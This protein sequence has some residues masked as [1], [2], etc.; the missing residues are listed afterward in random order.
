MSLKPRKQHKHYPY[1]FLFNAKSF[2][3]YLRGQYVEYL[4]PC[5]CSGYYFSRTKLTVY[6]DTYLF[7]KLKVLINKLWEKNKLIYAPVLC[8]SWVV[9][10]DSLVIKRMK[11]YIRDSENLYQK[12]KTREKR[13]ARQQLRLNT[14]SSGWVAF[15]NKPTIENPM[16][17]PREKKW[18]QKGYDDA[19]K[20]YEQERNSDSDQYLNLLKFTEKDYDK[21]EI[22][23][24]PYIFKNGIYEL[25]D[26]AENILLT[27]EDFQSFFSFLENNHDALS[28]IIE[29]G[30]LQSNCVRTD[31]TP[32]LSSLI[33]FQEFIETIKPLLNSSIE[34]E[35]NNW[36]Q[37]GCQYINIDFLQKHI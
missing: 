7:N 14:W 12:R 13:E 26:G 16:L 37:L 30:E 11:S 25:I 9:N 20:D 29:S 21:A 31:G 27:K 33:M 4:M 36:K 18:W 34:D 19:K 10:N 8:D 2:L 24:I 3:K 32:Y 23:I 5:P 22:E 15:K 17:T 35:I 28:V 1:L 6:E